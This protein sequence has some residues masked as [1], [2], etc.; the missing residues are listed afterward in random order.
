M[1]RRWKCLKCFHV[2]IKEAVKD[3][4]VRYLCQNHIPD[5]PVRPRTYGRK[6]LVPDRNIPYCLVYF[7]SMKLRHL[8]STQLQWCLIRILKQ[9]FSTIKLKHLTQDIIGVKLS[10]KLVFYILF[11]WTFRYVEHPEASK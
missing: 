11:W 8:P 6:V 9:M 4:Q 3:T 10:G 1:N 7:L 2:P 5:L